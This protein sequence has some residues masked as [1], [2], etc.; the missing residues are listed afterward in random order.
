MSEALTIN[1]KKLL[2]IKEVVG[3]SKYTRDYIAKLA[4]D[5]QIVGAQV[6]RQWFIDDASLSKFVETTELETEVRKRHLSR[7]RRREREVK[8]VI[9]NRFDVVAAHPRYGARRGVVRALTLVVCGVLSGYALYA[10]P[11]L[12]VKTVS[13]QKAQSN[14]SVSTHVAPT[15]NAKHELPV[16]SLMLERAVFSD[17]QEAR[18][19]NPSA[20]GV[21]LLPKGGTVRSPE[22]IA[23]LFSD[24]VEVAFSNPGVGEVRLRDGSEK[25]MAVEF[26]TVPVTVAN[27]EGAAEVMTETP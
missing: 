23:A 7:E 5:G 14:L 4:R 26:V 16:S 21:L 9:K 27:S 22:E 10:A 13:L 11:D 18:S 1:G 25:G 2:P 6:G 12:V 19:F 3:R 24:P 17:T 15:E 20:E 8:S